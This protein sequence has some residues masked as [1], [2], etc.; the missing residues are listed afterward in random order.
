MP[1]I[2]K[3]APEISTLSINPYARES[4]REKRQQDTHRRSVQNHF[5]RRCELW[6]LHSTVHPKSGLISKSIFCTMP[7]LPLDME[8]KYLFEGPNTTALEPIFL[9][10]GRTL[11]KATFA[12]NSVKSSIVASFAPHKM[13]SP[14]A[15]HV[16]RGSSSGKIT[17]FFPQVCRFV[18]TFFD[19]ETIGSRAGRACRLA[20]DHVIGHYPPPS[21]SLSIAARPVRHAGTQGRRGRV[22]PARRWPPLI[23]LALS[24]P[25]CRAYLECCIQWRPE[26][27][28]DGVQGSLGHPPTL[29]SPPP[30]K[31][32]EQVV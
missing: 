30:P 15:I 4:S 3:H 5:S 22:M 1:H 29:N 7:T 19:P 21:S 26:V 32:F 27:S 23:S 25:Q 11:T 12:S 9:M 17:S 13:W 18:K 16:N 31:S 6:G 8:V 10:G 14:I 20:G 28:Q 2:T 24:V